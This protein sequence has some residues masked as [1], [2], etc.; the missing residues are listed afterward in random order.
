M[1]TIVEQFVREPVRLPAG[2][3]KEFEETETCAPYLASCLTRPGI[4]YVSKR[5]ETITGYQCRAFNR[6]GLSFW[7]PLIH[8]ADMQ[9]VTAAIARAHHELATQDPRPSKPLRLDSRIKRSDGAW[10]WIRE[11]KFI[12]SYKDGKKNHILGCLQDITAQKEAEAGAVEDLLAK[13]RDTN[14]L[15]DAALS[16]QGNESSR[17][18]L[19]TS[20]N[21]LRVSAR[22]RQVLELVAAGHSSKQIADRLSISE[23]TVET[24]RRNLLKKFKVNNSAGLITEARRLNF[25]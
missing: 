12:I 4:L 13:E 2:L 9:G 22:E 25:I 3:W 7:F 8:P 18:S 17:R 14:A 5:F 20:G 21:R 1:K 19:E 15:L 16:Y 6:D 23:N 24:H 11:L 10:V